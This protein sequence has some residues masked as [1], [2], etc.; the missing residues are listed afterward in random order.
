MITGSCWAT[1][2][3]QKKWYEEDVSLRNRRYYRRALILCRCLVKRSCPTGSQS[4][5]RLFPAAEALRLAAR[6]GH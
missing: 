1:K 4:W 5:R 2:K 6:R 3:L